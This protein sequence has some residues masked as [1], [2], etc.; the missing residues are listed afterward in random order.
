MDIKII[1]KYSLSTDQER[2]NSFEEIQQ[3]DNYNDIVDLDCSYNRPRG[4][5]ENSSSGY[6]KKKVK[7]HW[8]RWR[9]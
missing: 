5:L 2:Y 7:Q 3:L 9:R 1:I 6:N 8:P 4:Q